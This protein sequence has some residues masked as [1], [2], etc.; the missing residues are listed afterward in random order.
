MAPD[1]ADVDVPA[2]AAHATGEAMDGNEDAQGHCDVNRDDSEVRARHSGDAGSAR[3]SIAHALIP[4]AVPDPSSPG[5]TA[6]TPAGTVSANAAAPPV[7]NG[8]RYLSRCQV[9]RAVTGTFTPQSPM[10]CMAGVPAVTVT[11]AE[12]EAAPAHVASVEPLQPALVLAALDLEHAKE[13]ARA[14]ERSLLRERLWGIDYTHGRCGA[15]G[16]VS[17][18]RPW[19]C[20]LTVEAYRE[21]VLGESSPLRCRSSST[22]SP[23]SSAVSSPRSE[24]R[25]RPSS[26]RGRTPSKLPTS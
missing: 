3:S 25:A 5:G 26:V 12:R 9:G 18:W 20:A 6:A 4:A 13:A 17:R 22:S 21:L 16:A 7:R 11:H 15:S 14:E 19:R 2:D 23:P 10:A 8:L 1:S 24:A